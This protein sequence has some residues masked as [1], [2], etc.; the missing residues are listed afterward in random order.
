MQNDKDDAK[1]SRSPEVLQ[2]SQS[3][4]T[5]PIISLPDHPEYDENHITI[6]HGVFCDGPECSQTSLGAPIKGIR[7]KC[8][9]CA[10]V[11]F[12]ASCLSSSASPHDRSHAVLE[13]VKQA[14]FVDVRGMNQQ[15]KTKTMD[16]L[17]SEFRRLELVETG[18]GNVEAEGER[19]KL[20]D[21]DGTGSED[22]EE[23]VVIRRVGPEPPKDAKGWVN[24]YDIGPDG[25]VTVKSRPPGPSSREG[26][27]QSV[28][29]HQ[30]ADLL[31]KVFS[32]QL[33]EYDYF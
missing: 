5:N 29:H 18:D 11:D 8:T 9:V 27:T 25:S 2:T 4:T 1:T 14:R 30:D 17:G 33:E 26:R 28:M 15:E 10:D 24:Q 7:Y 6:H 12:C 32:R 21:A 19:L 3:Q 22:L 16:D 31:M 23:S 20:K 13:C